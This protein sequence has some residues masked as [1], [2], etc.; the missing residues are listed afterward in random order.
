MQFHPLADLFPLIEGA[1]FDE[2]VASIKAHGLR[3]EITTFE[4]T[5]LDGRNRYRACKVADVEPRFEEFEGDDIHAFVADKNIHRRHLNESQRAL[6]GAG[7][8]TMKRGENLHMPADGQ[9][10]PSEISADRAAQLMN[11]G[12][13]SIMA[14][15]LVIAK[16]T[17]EELSAVKEGRA[18]VSTIAEQIRANVPSAERHLG[19]KDSPNMRAFHKKNA[20]AQ[21]MKAQVWAQLRDGINALSGLP[22]AADV[23]PIARSM[24]KTGLVDTKLFSTLQFLKDFAH[25]WSKRSQTTA[26]CDDGD[27]HSHAATGD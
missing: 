23:V 3:E 4:G 21:Q 24:D 2:L 19:G 12:R 20:T 11:V 10:R 6:I 17:P 14:A 5:I 15:K 26:A 1:E 25:E 13:G 27:D 18:S 9:I 7:M 22:R 8:A 16:G